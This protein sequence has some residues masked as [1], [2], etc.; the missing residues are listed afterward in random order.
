MDQIGCQ[1]LLFYPLNLYS[2][3]FYAIFILF[4]VSGLLTYWNFRE[5]GPPSR[6]DRPI[7]P[8]L[9]PPKNK[10]M[11]KS[12]GDVNV[13]RSSFVKEFRSIIKMKVIN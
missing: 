4:I 6:K 12:V 5:T 8:A 10:N 9:I 3:L 7:L 13:D 11:E 1:D 2:A